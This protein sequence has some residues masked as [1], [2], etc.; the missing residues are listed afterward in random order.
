MIEQIFS[1]IKQ[2]LSLSFMVLRGTMSA[3]YEVFAKIIRNA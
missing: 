3:L 1:S 2:K